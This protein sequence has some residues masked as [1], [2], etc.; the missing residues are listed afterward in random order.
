MK[1]I[2]VSLR[3]VLG[4]DD[5]IDDNPT[6]LSNVNAAVFK[7]TNKKWSF[8]GTPITRTILIIL[9]TMR[10]NKNEQMISLSI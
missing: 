4:I 8:S 6:P 2:Q 1:A 9:R 5:E 7:K 10:T 3:A